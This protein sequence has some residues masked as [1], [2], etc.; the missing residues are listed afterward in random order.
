MFLGDPDGERSSARAAGPESS[1]RLLLSRPYRRTQGQ[2]PSFFLGALGGQGGS[3]CSWYFLREE[4]GEFGPQGAGWWRT[5][6]T[7]HC[8]P[9]SPHQLLEGLVHIEAQFGRGLKVG[10]VVGGAEGGGFGSGNL[11]RGTWR[12]QVPAFK[13]GPRDFPG[14]PVVKALRSQCRGPGFHPW[15]GN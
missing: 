14:G 11:G 8:S 12:S 2:P 15:S 7:G 10:H 1:C 5:T 6:A 3:S 9:D 4:A 13:A